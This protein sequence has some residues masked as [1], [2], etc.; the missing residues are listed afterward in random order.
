MATFSHRR[1]THPHKHAERKAMERIRANIKM[2]IKKIMA[3]KN[4]GKTGYE[5][6]PKL[7]NSKRWEWL[8]LRTFARDN[9]TCKLCNRFT[10]APQ[11][12]HIIPHGGDSDLFY[13]EQN[14]Q[15]LCITCHNRK[16]AKEHRGKISGCD[17]C[18]IPIDN[19]H[20]WNTGGGGK[21]V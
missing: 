4:T 8:R 11:C 10:P 20:P 5:K 1:G 15:T 13:D 17:V 19:K 16:T 9:Y 6:Y 18:G 12:D 14:L 7:F 3:Q 2:V 21:N